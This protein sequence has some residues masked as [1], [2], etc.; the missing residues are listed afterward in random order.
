MCQHHSSKKNTQTK[1]STMGRVKQIASSQNSSQESSVVK[2]AGT[3]KRGRPP[4]TPGSGS[5]KSAG[6]KK[7]A[8]SI[9]W[10]LKRQGIPNF[11]LSIHRTLKQVHPNQTISKNSM[12]ILYVPGLGLWL[13]FYSPNF[14]LVPV[15]PHL[16]STT[17]SPPHTRN[18]TRSNSFCNDM[19]S[20]VL[21]EARTLLLMGGPGG[22]KTLSARTLQ[23]SARLL[24]PGELA[25][26]AIAEGTKAVT[27]F[28]NGGELN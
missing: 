15:E 23:T 12:S 22:V 7:T 2:S 13:G 14:S 10:T 6:K 24:L 25:K 17:P 5:Q 20:R 19:M 11:H 18:F 16:I 21:K 9:S 1:K 3:G 4:S 8:K 27:K 28:N 26:H